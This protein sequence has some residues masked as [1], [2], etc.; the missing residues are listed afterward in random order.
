MSRKNAFTALINFCSL[1]FL[2][3]FPI[4]PKR[5]SRAIT[6]IAS[7]VHR[8]SSS[9][10]LAGSSNVTGS[11]ITF[12][13]C[14][15]FAGVKFDYSN[16]NELKQMLPLN[17]IIRNLV[18]CWD[19]QLHYFRL[20]HHRIHSWP[21]ISP[22]FTLPSERIILKIY[23]IF[24]YDWSTYSVPRPPLINTSGRRLCL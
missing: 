8:L 22:K 19:I 12:I 24:F 11:R 23:K 5:V 9:S 18:D 2:S 21:H 10:K 3:N 13:L 1:L 6:Q 14:R 16:G 4:K 20:H 17:K 7:K 15:R